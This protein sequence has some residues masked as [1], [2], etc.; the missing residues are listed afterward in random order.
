V[1]GLEQQ[2]RGHT[3]DISSAAGDQQSHGDPPSPPRR[4]DDGP[5]Y[6]VGSV[7]RPASRAAERRHPGTGR[8]AST[9]STQEVNRG[10]RTPSGRRH[11]RRAVR[12][13]RPGR[14]GRSAGPA[15][16][17]GGGTR[18]VTFAA[19]PASI[20]SHVLWP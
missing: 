1:A 6:L 12:A 9:S 2:R 11:V 13:D 17:P 15:G 10:R 18:D 7:P 5:H 3:S 20:D 19:G 14:T 16:S 4:I 8:T